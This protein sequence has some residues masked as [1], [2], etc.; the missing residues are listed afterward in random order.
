MK[1]KDNFRKNT[2]SCL[3]KMHQPPNLSYMHSDCSCTHKAHKQSPIN[4]NM[5]VCSALSKPEPRYQG[6]INVFSWEEGLEERRREVRIQTLSQTP[7]VSCMPMAQ[8]ILFSFQKTII[9]RQ[10]RFSVKSQFSV[11]SFAFANRFIQI[12]LKIKALESKRYMYNKS[13]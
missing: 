4:C 10:A 2:H 7:H 5:Q 13:H 1:A 8:G 12:M 6:F 9:S 3:V 11:N